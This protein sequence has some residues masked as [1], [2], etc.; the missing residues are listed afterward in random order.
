MTIGR[1]QQVELLLAGRVKG[2]A[3]VVG[4]GDLV[5]V[6]RAWKHIAWTLSNLYGSTFEQQISIQT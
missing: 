6:L 4:R 2:E 3:K 5:N 1:Q